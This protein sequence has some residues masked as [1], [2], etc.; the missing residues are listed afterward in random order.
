MNLY[1]RFHMMKKRKITDA[2]NLDTILPNRSI[3]KPV[4]CF[5]HQFFTSLRF[6]FKGEI[7]IF[8]NKYT[9]RNRLLLHITCIAN[10]AIMNED[11]DPSRNNQKS[12]HH[13]I[14]LKYTC[15]CINISLFPLHQQPLVN[16]GLSFV[17]VLDGMTF[18]CKAVKDDIAI[19]LL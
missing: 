7:V 13:S 11:I 15:T 2:H 17:E 4:D 9:Q 16:P 1:V 3:V 12:R 8:M 14:I 19:A 5:R 6:Q 18:T 10:I